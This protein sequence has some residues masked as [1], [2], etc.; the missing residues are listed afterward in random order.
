MAGIVAVASAVA[1]TPLW[2]RYP[3][4]SPDGSTIAFCYQGDIFTVPSSGGAAKRITTNPAYDYM[5]VWSPD[6]RSIAFASDRNGNMD[7]YVV[8]AEG[9]V[10]RA[11]TVNSVNETPVLFIDN[12][13]ILYSASMLPDR[14]DIQFPSGQFPQLY[15]IPVTGGRPV[16]F[17]SLAMENLSV[18]PVDGTI[19]YNDKKVMKILGASITVHQSHVTYGHVRPMLNRHSKN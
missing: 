2:L 4:I 16:M 18:N 9:G 13:H 15:K 1:D 3:A 12:D 7:V 19:L 6:G 14:K 5:P 17:S 8:S 11:V 10:P